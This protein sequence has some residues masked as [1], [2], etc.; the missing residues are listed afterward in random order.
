MYLYC[1]LEVNSCEVSKGL[2]SDLLRFWVLVH[3]KNGR[4]KN[5]SSISLLKYPAY[6]K[7][8]HWLNWG[9]THTLTEP[10]GYQVFED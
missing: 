9:F 8:Y 6:L 7:D 2:A 5:V 4:E 10:Y 1:T 3:L